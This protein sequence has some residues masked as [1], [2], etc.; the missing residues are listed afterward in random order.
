ME[1]QGGK[2]TRPIPLEL[3]GKPEQRSFAFDAPSLGPFLCKWDTVAHLESVVQLSRAGPPQQGAACNPRTT[4]RPIPL[5][6][7]GKQLQPQWL[8]DQR[9]RLLRIFFGKHRSC[10]EEVLDH[11]ARPTCCAQVPRLP[12]TP[13]SL[14]AAA[15]VPSKDSTRR[16]L[17]SSRVGR[18]GSPRDSCTAANTRGCMLKIHAH[19]WPVRL[20]RM[21]RMQA[22]R[23]RR[24][25]TWVASVV[26]VDS[27][28][29]GAREVV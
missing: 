4:T 27:K 25:A 5:E 17:S 6:V 13:P 12:V 28:I 15:R 10:S 1:S 14:E 11:R 20:P 3:V 9:P 22:L 21:P 7:V 16:P 19:K 29:H 26:G 23:R 18:G 2:T 24:H 8:W